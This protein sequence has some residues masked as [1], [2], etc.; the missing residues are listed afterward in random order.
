[1][2]TNNDIVRES[3]IEILEATLE[4][5]LRAIRKLKNGQKKMVTS[6]NKGMSQVDLA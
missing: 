3:I 2:S 1:M 6:A 5:Q 4:A